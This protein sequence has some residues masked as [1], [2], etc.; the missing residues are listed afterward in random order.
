[1]NTKLYLF[2]IVILL[3]CISCDKSTDEFQPGT[4]TEVTI[5]TAYGKWTYFSFAKGDTVGTGVANA[6][7]G[8]EW[9]ERTDWDL[10][11]LINNVRTN[12]GTS[13]EGQGGAY[14]AE[15]ADFQSVNGAKI[16]GYTVDTNVDNIMYNMPPI[17]GVG[18]DTVSVNAELATW[19]TPNE[20]DKTFDVNPRIFVVKTADGKYA[21]IYL[22]SIT[23]DPQNPRT[24]RLVTMEYFYQ[25]DG[26]RFLGTVIEE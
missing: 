15:T 6:I 16:E 11:F 22:K 4:G 21:K 5:A 13:G 25:P 17:P 7:T 14:Y 20:A 23:T 18:M 1:M 10:A 2:A 9:S 26:S 19:T 3:A 24:G 8:S 12:S